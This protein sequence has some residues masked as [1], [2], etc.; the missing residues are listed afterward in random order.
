M[1]LHGW[2][3]CQDAEARMLL[4][5]IVASSCIE[6]IIIIVHTVWPIKLHPNH[7]AYSTGY[8]KKIYIYMTGSCVFQQCRLFMAIYVLSLSLS[9]CV[10]C[11]GRMLFSFKQKK[12]T[13]KVQRWKRARAVVWRQVTIA[14]KKCRTLQKK[15]NRNM[16]FVP[17]SVPMQ[18]VH[19]HHN[20]PLMAKPV[21]G[22][23]AIHDTRKCC[24]WQLNTK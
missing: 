4:Q 19:P 3:R 16:I 13:A 24:L 6:I 7:I 18:V 17:N 10:Y 15:R 22:T 20:C 23:Y 9:V 21:P 1:R 14:H 5:H 8:M 11:H 12:V 2:R